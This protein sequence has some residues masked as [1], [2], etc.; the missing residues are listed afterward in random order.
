MEAR[1]AEKI[2][3]KNGY[4]SIRG[5]KSGSHR[6]YGKPGCPTVTIPFH[7]SKD[8]TIGVLKS[9]EKQTGLSFRR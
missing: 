8:L 6:Q 3:K 5:K 2:L 4:V 1:K 7:G 9:L